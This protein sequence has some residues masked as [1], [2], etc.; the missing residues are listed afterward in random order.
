MK[1]NIHRLCNT[2][3][4]HTLDQAEDNEGSTAATTAGSSIR[5]SSGTIKTGDPLIDQIRDTT[6]MK[7]SRAIQHV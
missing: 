5:C 2:D 4:I 7:Y 3:P 6:P 1:K